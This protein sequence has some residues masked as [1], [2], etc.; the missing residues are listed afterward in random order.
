MSTKTTSQTQQ[1][2]GP[3]AAAASAFDKMAE[4]NIARMEAFFQEMTKLQTKSMEQS[5][6][7]IDEAA[8]LMKEQMQYSAKLATEWQRMALET[9]RQAAQMMGKPWM[10]S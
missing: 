9:S 4:D 1:N 7:A 2:E 6:A 8:K 3:A 5:V 10:L